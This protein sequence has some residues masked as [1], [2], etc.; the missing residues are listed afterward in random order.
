[1][2]LRQLQRRSTAIASRRLPLRRM[3]LATQ[4]NNVLAQALSLSPYF[5]HLDGKRP[6][7]GYEPA[8]AH[9][10]IPHHV[11]SAPLK[12]SELDERSYRMIRLDNGLEALLVS[13]PKTDKA[14]ASLCVRVGHLSDPVGPVAPCMT[15]P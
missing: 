15:W 2:L 10:G 8:S 5:D 7:K 12:K 4:A 1:M 13:D 14:A 3:L 6:P 9:G 11:F